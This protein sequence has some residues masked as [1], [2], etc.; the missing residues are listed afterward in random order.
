MTDRDRMSGFAMGASHAARLEQAA[1]RY[2][3]HYNERVTAIVR[4]WAVDLWGERC[5]KADADIA[6]VFVLLGYQFLRVIPAD[7]GVSTLTL[8]LNGKTVASAGV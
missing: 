7:G 6:L 5:P 4:Q 1:E 8:S 3:Q 2:R